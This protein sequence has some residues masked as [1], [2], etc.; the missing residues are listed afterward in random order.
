MIPT[1]N[2]QWSFE[3]QAFPS[4]AD[5]GANEIDTLSDSS[6]GASVDRLS[7]SSENDFEEMSVDDVLHGWGMGSL[8]ANLLPILLVLE[9]LAFHILKKEWSSILLSAR[10]H[11]TLVSPDGT[12]VRADQPLFASLSWPPPASSFWS[13]AASACPPP[14]PSE[15]DVVHLNSEDA[16]LKA[17]IITKT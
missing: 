6:C 5:P 4:R 7:P 14:A 1:F 15:L 2:F 12:V 8:D 10:W 11:R 9:P 13:A 3:R 16:F 17:E